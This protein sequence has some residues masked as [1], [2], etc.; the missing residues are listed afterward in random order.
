MPP[1]MTRLRPDLRDDKSSM[2]ARCAA[3][4]SRPGWKPVRDSL[5]AP[6]LQKLQIFGMRHML[7]HLSRG[8]L[9]RWHVEDDSSDCS[10]KPIV[11]VTMFGNAQTTGRRLGVLRRLPRLLRPGVLPDG[12]LVLLAGT[13]GAVAGL[14]PLPQ[15]LGD[16][17]PPGVVAD[18]EAL[19]G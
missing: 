11:P 2:A 10:V 3:K 1:T 17:V 7:R 9:G 14:D 5:S 16:V 19:V 4:Q 6:H 18:V 15:A 12:G 8:L 13:H